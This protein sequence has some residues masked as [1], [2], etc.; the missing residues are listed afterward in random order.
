MGGGQAT[1]PEAAGRRHPLPLH[2]PEGQDTSALQKRGNIEAI[3]P[4]GAG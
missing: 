3:G 4:A 2:Y 1:Q